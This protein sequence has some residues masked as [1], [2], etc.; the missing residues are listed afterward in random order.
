MRASA[1]RM[2]RAQEA[3]VKRDLRSRR[4]IKLKRELDEKKSQDGTTT[5]NRAR[6]AGALPRRTAVHATSGVTF[7]VPHLAEIPEAIEPPQLGLRSRATPF[8]LRSSSAATRR[9]KRAHS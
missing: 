7:D 6:V 8:R 5:S 9:Q 2:P 4:W 3:P 1:L